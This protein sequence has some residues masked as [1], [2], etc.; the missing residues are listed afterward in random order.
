[1]NFIESDIPSLDFIIN[2]TLELD[3]VYSNELTDANFLDKKDKDRENKFNYLLSIIKSYDCAKVNPARNEDN[4][5]NTE[6]NQLTE[7]FKNDGGFTSAFKDLQNEMSHNENLKQKTEQKEQ[8][9]I[10]NLKLQN[11]NLE[12]SKTIREQ[13]TRIRNL[14][15]KTKFI[16]LLKLYWWVLIGCIGIGIGAKEFWDLTM[17]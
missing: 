15:E 9:E 11:E 16:E 17:K 14:E 7:K 12:Y 4:G 10:E 6:R 1:M 2:R 5:A 13:L 8:L 3:R